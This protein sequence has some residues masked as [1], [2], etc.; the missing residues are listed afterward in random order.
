LRRKNK[1]KKSRKTID[2]SK[3]KFTLIFVKVI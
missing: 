1:K 2:E 3:K